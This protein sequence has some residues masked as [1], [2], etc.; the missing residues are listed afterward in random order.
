M[1]S[2]RLIVGLVAAIAIA[3]TLQVSR[4][5][6]FVA[7][8][9]RDSGHFVYVEVGPAGPRAPWGKAV[10][11]INGDGLTDLVVGGHQQRRLSLVERIGRKV[12]IRSYDDEL[13]ELVW[14]AGP[15]WEKHL[16]STKYAIRTDIEIGDI[17]G[18]GRADIVALTDVG[19]GWFRN[20]DW[21]FS[22]IDDPVM[23]DVELAD[24][25]QDL[26][27]EIVVRN[28]SLFGYENGN[29]VY[30]YDRTENGSWS[31]E[32]LAAPH[33]EG[34]LVTDVNGD[35][36]PDIIVNTIGYYNVP[37]ES[38]ALSWQRFEY[39]TDWTWNDV[40][41]GAGD[42]DGDGHIDIVLAPAEP[43]GQRYRIS[44][45]R[46]PD[47]IAEEWQESVV[48]DD[49][50]AVHHFVGTADF[51]GDGLADIATAQ[52]T[53]GDDPDEVAIYFNRERGESWEKEVLAV[54]GSHSMRILDADGDLRPDLFGANWQKDGYFG[55]YPVDLWINEYLQPSALQWKRHV[56]D[57]ERPGQAVFIFANDIDGDGNPD[58][59]SGA[60]WYRNPGELSGTWE[61]SA[62]GER[63]NNVSLVHDFDMD[64]QPDL[65]AS[66][67]RGYSSAPSIW[68]R[69]LNRTGIK[70]YDYR[71]AGGEFV[72]AR[73]LGD[74]QFA[75]HDNIEPATG[76]FLQGAA[77]LRRQHEDAVVL[78]WHDAQ[79]SLQMLHLPANR[80]DSIWTW[81]E[82]STYS[83]HEQ[84]TIADI[85]GDGVDDILLGTKWMQST[86]E[87]GLW[88]LRTLHETD[89]PPDR[90][91]VADLNGNGRPDVVIGYE[92]VSRLGQLAW[93]EAGSDPTAPWTEYLVAELT[94]PMSIDVADLD[95]DGDLDI[96]VG[97]HNLDHPDNARLVWVENVTGDG[98]G[99]VRHLIHTGDEHHNGA[100]AVDIDGDGDLD[101]VSI[102]WGHKRVFLYE[103]LR[104]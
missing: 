57:A 89:E 27:L 28:Q 70:S 47:D 8:P 68:Q 86:D 38:G 24:I 71:N 16:V 45:F 29:S 84:I 49:T 69:I 83:Q 44:W 65:L 66:N 72:W 82:L 13:G 10:G 51:D 99:W 63:A 20:P 91:R 42:F 33:G 9:V 1:S 4:K 39:A 35:G 58:I 79:T 50:E 32:T 43:V 53:Q 90:H 93:Y 62:I 81:S 14:Y 48:V 87:A 19:I 6:P 21:H 41:V 56:I 17:D 76:D 97:E 104:H 80:V 73:N 92:A 74:G 37:G 22:L 23:H 96:V 46:A 31:K 15:T 85:N 25:D 60:W 67:W 12:G 3:A 11:D 52:M 7:E 75:I 98:Q 95:G 55:D 61:R 59:I 54:S 34:L 94:G 36:R 18:D 103:N 26:Q 101:I 77:L 100:Q 88:Q 40:F 64:G 78:S 102:G 2:T 30:I 5:A